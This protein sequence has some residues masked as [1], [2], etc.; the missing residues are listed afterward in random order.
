MD[1]TAIPVASS[2]SYDADVTAAKRLLLD[3][4]E[5]IENATGDLISLVN[6]FDWM[7]GAVGAL[8]AEL[9]SD[10]QAGDL[11]TL[12]AWEAPATAYLFTAAIADGDQAEADA[13]WKPLDKPA[14]ADV[15]L[16]LAA[17]LKVNMRA[18]FSGA[19][20]SDGRFAVAGALAK[21]NVDAATVRCISVSTFAEMCRNT[22]HRASVVG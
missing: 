18:A 11:D 14:Q 22:A 20:T 9:L 2:G 4:R 7:P 21:M 12:S 19:G 5:R 1:R 15:M 8:A 3:V 10:P 13:V 16:A 17:Q 6:A